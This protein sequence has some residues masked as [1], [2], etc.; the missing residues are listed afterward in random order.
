M[1]TIYMI[2][3][4]NSLKDFLFLSMI[5]FLKISYQKIL[6]YVIIG[7]WYEKIKFVYA[8]A[9]SSIENKHFDSH[10]PIQ[11]NCKMLIMPKIYSSS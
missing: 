5:K 7:L 3:Y 4:R 10:E 9:E 2:V 11:V 6:K 1:K 8:Y